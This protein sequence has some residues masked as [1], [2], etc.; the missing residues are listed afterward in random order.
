M[1]DKKT[2]IKVTNRDSGSVGY[3]IP[4][5][6]N[7]YRRFSAGETKTLTFEELEKL[8]WIPGGKRIL[9]NYLKLDNEE[10]VAELLGEVQPEYYYSEDEV[11]IL[12]SPEGTVEQLEDCLRY[13]PDGVLELIKK[14]AV[15]TKLNDLAKRNA[16]KKILNFDV[17]AA[18]MVNEA[19]AE[20]EGENTQVK[21][22]RKS[23]PIKVTAKGDRK[24]PVITVKK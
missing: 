14:T 17:S 21:T 8:S 11:K 22:G 2:L 7:L 5:L 3:V 18:I 9:T 6:N 16:I 15:E 1:I 23:E 24:A 12:L 10:A 20:G 4:D 19:S 13:A